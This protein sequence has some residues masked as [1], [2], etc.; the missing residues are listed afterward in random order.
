MTWRR[1]GA[2]SD[3]TPSAAFLFARLVQRSRIVHRSH[4]SV[5]K[6]PPRERGNPRAVG[7][8]L[9]SWKVSGLW[10]RR[11]GA[12]RSTRAIESKEVCRTDPRSAIWMT[13]L[14]EAAMPCHYFCCVR[15]P[16]PSGWRKILRRHS[17]VSHRLCS[18]KASKT[19]ASSCSCLSLARTNT[20]QSE[21]RRTL[22][23]V[24]ILNCRRTHG[25]SWAPPPP[26]TQGA[27][28]RNAAACVA[29][30][31]GW[32]GFQYYGTSDIDIT[33]VTR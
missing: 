28:D 21:R 22:G 32:L 18:A 23:N 9:Y 6:K 26:K 15:T 24:D 5:V 13:T 25:G 8:Y 30:S 10:A 20:A 11:R 33:A 14:L 16:A 29:S 7:R 31:T 3:G 27:T 1:Y 17:E 19:G 12:R 2:R 4:P